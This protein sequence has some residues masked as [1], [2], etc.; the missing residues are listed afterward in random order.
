MNLELSTDQ[1]SQQ[2]NRRFT[3]SKEMDG[4]VN[5]TL[6]EDFF[7]DLLCV[8]NDPE[9]F[10]ASDFMDYP[11]SSI[12][13]YLKKTHELYTTESLQ[14]VTNAIEVLSKRNPELST[15]KVGLDNFFSNFRNKLEEHI[16]EEEKTLFPYVE[17]LINAKDG[18]SMIKTTTESVLTDF[19]K[20]HDDELEED[21]RDLVVALK[22]LP[23]KYNDDSFAFRMLLNKVS[24]FERD[25]NVHGKIE[26][27]VLIPKALVLE[28]ASLNR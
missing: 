10:D 9:R 11:I 6:D 27:Q 16:E 3:G 24:I 7:V 1:F 28:K 26:E 13:L 19:L 17:S 18:D 14:G 12:L 4:T 8:F 2:I 22:T 15:L 20:H 25:L 21:L 23:K 5:S